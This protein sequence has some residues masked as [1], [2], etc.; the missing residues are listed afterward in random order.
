MGWNAECN[1]PTLEVGSQLRVYF[2]PTVKGSPAPAMSP[3]SLL[4]HFMPDGTGK[5]EIVSTLPVFAI[6]YQ[7]SQWFAKPISV[8]EALGLPSVDWA[9]YSDWVVYKKEITSEAE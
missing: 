6:K 9:E 7:D 5:A 4:I 8:N 2:T 3:G 1:R